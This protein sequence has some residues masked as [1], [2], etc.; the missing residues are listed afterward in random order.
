MSVSLTQTVPPAPQTCRQL[1][2]R[3]KPGGSASSYVDG[4][5]WPR[6]RDLTAELPA[7]AKV[8]AVRLGSVWRVVYPLVS[9]DT[10][11]RRIQ[12][13]GHPVRLEGFHSQDESTISIVALDRQ[14][15]RLLVIPLDASK[16]AGHDAM[17]MAAGRDNADN[18]T[19]ILTTTTGARPSIVVP[20]PRGVDD[21]AEDRWDGDGGH[22]NTRHDL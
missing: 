17:T 9:W 11:P 8:L 7:L 12:F 5:W 14:R 13:D 20:A 21:N 3:L 10:A 2:L 15:V 16:K 19:T 6:S 1:R 18:P 4:A 22:I